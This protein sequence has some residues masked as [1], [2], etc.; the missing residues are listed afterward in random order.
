MKR[1]IVISSIVAIFSLAIF[2]CDKNED[3]KPVTGDV[4]LYLLESY[5]TVG[6]T[7]QIDETTVAIKQSALVSY[8]D[9]ISYN[10][11]EYIFEISD[12]S[13]EAI[14]DLEHS[15]QGIA[16]AIMADNKLIYTGYFWPCYSSAICN[17]VVTDPTSLLMSN[18]L[19]IS[20]R[21]PGPSQGVVIPDN[22]NDKQI[23]DIFRRDG[24]LL[25]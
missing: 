25:E 2:A 23:L 13:K 10:S 17:W 8:S 4:E 12:K 11:K 6:N 1:Q 7:C 16:F 14:Q 3:S 22:R 9:F 20:L 21:Y 19:R 18:E 5:E 24:K 15:V